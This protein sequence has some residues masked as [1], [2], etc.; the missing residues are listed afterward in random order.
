MFQDKI[1]KDFNGHTKEDEFKLGDL[2]LIWDTINEDKVKHGKFD[3]LW[4]RPFKI[5]SYHGSNAYLIQ[6]N[7]GDIIGGG[8]MNGRFL[9]HYIV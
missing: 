1:K 4:L 5:A 6:E 2:V 7:N 9:K 3:H 8:S